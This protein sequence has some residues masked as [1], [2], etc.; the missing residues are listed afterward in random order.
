MDTSN[1]TPLHGGIVIDATSQLSGLDPIR[2]A[3][4]EKRRPY[5]QA[6]YQANREKMLARSKAYNKAN[7]KK[8]QVYRKAHY[9]ANR[10]R[11]LKHSKEYY[12]AK[13]RAE[14]RERVDTVPRGTASLGGFSSYSAHEL[15]RVCGVSKGTAQRWR[16]T[17][18]APAVMVILLELLHRGPLELLS[19][20]WADWAIRKGKLCNK[21]GHEYTPGEIWAIPI[22]HQ[23]IAA[24]EASNRKLSADAELANR[25]HSNRDRLHRESKAIGK[26]EALCRVVFA[27]LSELTESEDGHPA[28]LDGRSALVRRVQ[29]STCQVAIELHR[30]SLLTPAASEAAIEAAMAAFERPAA[31][32]D[33][34]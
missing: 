22:L 9:Q 1:V 15:A 16:K 30:G 26:A 13:R 3:K 32:P 10:E 33:S 25:F 29:L 24:L 2:T 23:R 27:L 7:R 31:D 11:Y 14:E 6:Y 20:E 18:E 5:K 17:G 4:R 12:E 19:H 21:D 34:A 28:V 8:L